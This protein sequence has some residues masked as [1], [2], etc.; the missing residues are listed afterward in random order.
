M[1]LQMLNQHFPK[2]LAHSV[3]Q[4]KLKNCEIYNTSQWSM[5]GSQFFMQSF[6]AD[7]FYIFTS[8]F[9]ISNYYCFLHM[10]LNCKLPNIIVRTA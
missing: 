4:K 2:K 8:S 10:Y 1:Y 5:Y 9:L 3:V 6:E 7:Q